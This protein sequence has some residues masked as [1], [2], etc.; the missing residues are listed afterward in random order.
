[1]IWIISQALLYGLLSLA[2]MFSYKILDIAD[3]TVDGSYPLGVVVASVAMIQGVHP[4]LALFFSVL[5]GLLAGAMSGLLHIKLKITPLLSGILMMTALYSINLMIAGGR[6]NLPLFQEKTLF[7]MDAVLWIPEAYRSLVVLVLI[8]MISIFLVETFLKTSLGYLMKL[9]GTNEAMIKDLGHDAD[10][11]KVFALALSN[12]IAAFAG[13]I[14]ASLNA[15]FD[16]SLG[17]GMVVLGLS[18][19]LLGDSLFQKMTDKISLRV[20]MGALVYQMMIAFALRLDM[21]PHLLKLVTVGIFIFAL[22]LDKKEKGDLIR[23]A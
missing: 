18:S 16:I 1:M 17:T 3:L 11:I 23:N 8:A 5:A 4:V 13:G 20:F 6:S 7:K 19:I 12:G 10:Q 21:P 22:W 15:Y 9:L 14:A 2:V